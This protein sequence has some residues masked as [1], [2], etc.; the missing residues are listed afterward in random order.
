MAWLP[1]ETLIHAHQEEYCQVLNSAGISGESTDFTA[2][3]LKLLRDLL[4]D[5]KKASGKMSVIMSVKM[6]VMALIKTPARC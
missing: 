5:I 3:M 6:S 1:V 4:L 2:F